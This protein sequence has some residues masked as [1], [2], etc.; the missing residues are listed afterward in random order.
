MTFVARVGRSARFTGHGREA[1]MTAGIEGKC[2]S[3][4]PAEQQDRHEQ[5]KH[6]LHGT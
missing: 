5:G 1:M 4:D 6:A 2:V 3:P